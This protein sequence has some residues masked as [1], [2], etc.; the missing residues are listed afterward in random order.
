MET[1]LKLDVFWDVSFICYKSFW[2]SVCTNRAP[3]M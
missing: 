2:N 1:C 3:I